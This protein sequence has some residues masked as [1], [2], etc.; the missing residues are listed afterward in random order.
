[1]LKLSSDFFSVWW[2]LVFL[3]PIFR[4]RGEGRGSLLG[5]FITAMGALFNLGAGYQKWKLA[6]GYSRHPFSNITV[7]NSKIPLYWLLG[8]RMNEDTYSL[9]KL[10]ISFLKSATEHKVQ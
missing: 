2:V 7:V 8:L 5:T 4:W 1:M 9:Y 3:C 6:S 10:L